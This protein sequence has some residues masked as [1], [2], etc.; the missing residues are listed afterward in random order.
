[1]DPILPR[2][3]PLVLKK[4]K[5]LVRFHVRNLLTFLFLLSFFST[6]PDPILILL[7]FLL[8]GLTFRHSLAWLCPLMDRWWVTD[9]SKQNLQKPNEPHT[10]SKVGSIHA[11]C[12]LDQDYWN[13]GCFG[14]YFGLH[15][16]LYILGFRVLE[17]FC[18]LPFLWLLPLLVAVLVWSVWPVGILHRLL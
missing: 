6:L 2:L 3:R 15:D 1:M 13:F 5:Y 7:K 16:L 8:P 11:F 9:I 4:L 12:L 18:N 14:Y 10:S 17:S